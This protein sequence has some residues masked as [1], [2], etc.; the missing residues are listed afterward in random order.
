MATF[1]GIPLKDGSVYTIAIPT[2]G[3]DDPLS[4]SDEVILELWERLCPN[5]TTAE[6]GY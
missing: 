6:S 4:R 1:R 2:S 3:T 5:P